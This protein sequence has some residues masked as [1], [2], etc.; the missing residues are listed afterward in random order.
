MQEDFF[1]LR[2][3]SWDNSFTKLKVDDLW[4]TNKKMAESLDITNF[5]MNYKAETMATTVFQIGMVHQGPIPQYLLFTY[6]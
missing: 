1:S 6:R 4:A 5:D 3:Y 2:S